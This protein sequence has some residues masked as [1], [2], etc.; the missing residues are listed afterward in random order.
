M[1]PKEKATELYKKM[2]SVIETPSNKLRKQRAKETALIAVNEIIEQWNYIDT[3]LANGNG[4][5]N[6]NLKYW[7]A[8]KTELQ[9]L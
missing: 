6:P 8:V 3:Y 7:Y 4:E 2:H 5:L 9:S 1:E